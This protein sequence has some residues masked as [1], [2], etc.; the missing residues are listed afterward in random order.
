LK[1]RT[2]NLLRGLNTVLAYVEGRPTPGTRSVT[3]HVPD[4]K[5]IREQ[6]KMSQSEFASAYRIPV[7]TL[8]NWEQGVRRPD[9]PATAYLRVI[10]RHPKTVREAVAK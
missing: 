8:R 6:L 4:V 10:A 9:A 5:A 2:R 7:G 3:V 1:K